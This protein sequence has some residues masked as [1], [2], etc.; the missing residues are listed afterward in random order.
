MDKTESTETPIKL[1]L[2]KRLELAKDAIARGEWMVRA[3]NNGVSYHNSNFS[4]QPVGLWTE[5]EQWDAAPSCGHGLH[6]QGSEAGGYICGTRMVFCETEGEHVMI[7][8]DKIKVPRARILLIGDE[9]AQLDVPLKF[10]TDLYLSGTAITSLPEKLEVSDEVHWDGRWYQ[11][12]KSVR[13][14]MD[15]EASQS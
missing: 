6:G 15:L 2:K 4:W 14:A 11:S 10:E 13:K 9:W 8:D 5:C 1:T 3:D 12:V 7:G